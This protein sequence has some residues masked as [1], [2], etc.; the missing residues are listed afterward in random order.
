M[1][2]ARRH[3]TKLLRPLVGVRFQD[4]FHSLT[5]GSFHLSLTVLVHYRSLRSIQPYRMV[6]VDSYR[7]TRVPHYSGYHYL[8]FAY[9]YG[10]ITLYGLSFQTVLIHL[11]SNIVVLQPQYCRNNTGLGCSNFARRYYR[12]HFCFLFLRVLRCFSSPGLPP[13]GYYIFNIVGCPIRKSS[14]QR[15]CA[16][17]RSL[18][19]LITS[20]IVSES[21]GIPHTLLICL[22]YFFAL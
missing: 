6:P 21:L 20:F 8:I 2:K 7:I 16:P 13:C 22:L 4:L 3:N 9:L 11:A 17:P 12:N 5:Q 14:D 1:Q 15:V 18:S 10:T 19:Q